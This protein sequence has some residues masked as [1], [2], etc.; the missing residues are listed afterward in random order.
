MP[1]P[2][3]LIADDVH[4]R[5]KKFAEMNHWVNQDSIPAKLLQ[6]LWQQSSFCARI[7]VQQPDVIKELSKQTSSSVNDVALDYL[8]MLRSATADVADEDQFKQC[9]R[10][11]RNAQLVKLCWQDLVLQ[12]DVFREND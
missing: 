6:S 9:I 3:I 10:R 4:A 2:E 12:V 11:F 1:T 7:C 8:E 5:W